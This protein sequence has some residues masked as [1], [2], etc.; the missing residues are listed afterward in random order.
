[1]AADVTRIIGVDFGTSTSV[2]CVKRYKDGSPVGDAFSSSYVTFGNGQ[3]DARAYTLVRRNSDGTYTC[4]REA[5]DEAPGSEVF[6]EFKMDLES[7]DE[8]KRARARSLT[9][10]FFGYLYRW[11]DHQRSDMGD[12]GDREKTIVSF[13]AKWSEGTRA[14][15]AEAA[16]K[17]G[18]PD[19]SV[20][21]EPSAALYATLTRKMN[22]VSANG[23]L[24]TGKPGYMLLID[25]GAGTTDL[26]V[27]RY[28]VT[29][30][31]GDVIRA[32][33]IKNELVA[34]WPES[35]DAPTFGG[36]EV[37][38][39]LEDYLTEYMTSCGLAGDMAR[40]LV[41][42]ADSVKAWKEDTVSARLNDGAVVDS[43]GFLSGYMM[44]L[45]QKRPFPAIDRAKLEGMLGEKLNGFK[46]LVTGCLDR[47]G[48]L[49]P[50][51][52][53][54][55]L[56]LVVLTGGHSAWYF[57]EALL[58]GVMPGV[59]HPA[60]RRV[61]AEKARVMRLSNPQETVALGL[62]YSL[63]PLR[64]T[65][66]KQPLP[67]QEKLV[68]Q[69]E[70]FFS[71]W[72]MD[73]DHTSPWMVTQPAPSVIRWWHNQ[74]KQYTISFGETGLHINN[75]FGSSH[76]WQED[77]SWQDLLSGHII[78]DTLDSLEVERGDEAPLRLTYAS[79]DFVEY[80]HKFFV[81]LQAALRE[82]PTAY[83][84]DDRL[85]PKAKE[86]IRKNLKPGWHVFDEP[87]K[88][89]VLRTRVEI[90]ADADICLAYSWTVFRSNLGKDGWAITD[91]GFYSR[92]VFESPKFTSWGTFLNNL[93]LGR[94]SDVL[95]LDQQGHRSV[96]LNLY[97]SGD[98][99]IIE[100]AS[101][102]LRLQE[103]L[104]EESL[105]LQAKT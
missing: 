72:A 97:G 75:L 31:S 60:L 53:E 96:F 81:K 39:L 43:C 13:P 56:D 15:M 36:R 4:G 18:F 69:A 17:A 95:Q 42:R 57:T 44:L 76:R 54:Q 103:Y 23:F 51:I 16:K 33:Q 85:Y 104:Q 100:V 38:R 35:A 1:M 101:M 78:S 93:L 64:Q 6:R 79:F 32:E 52:R 25:M 82:K 34:T 99:K 74:S 68:E 55:G 8:A 28:T 29:A 59:S 47:A 77:I 58:N 12:A 22:D 88:I 71:R 45:P 90:P 24:R 5:G 61:Q 67:S 102:I 7:P 87:D 83:A 21:D 11:Y 2:V 40:Q 26:A 94:Y 20:M 63:L 62:V 70:Q 91:R 49:E 9:E 92:V 65:R 66:E 50:A 80:L 73:P 19:V 98:K 27:C 86:F 10:E 30:G 48:A 14:F 46:A 89:E 84:W 37:D 3:G 105:A 41:C